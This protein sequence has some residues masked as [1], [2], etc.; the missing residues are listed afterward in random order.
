M[1]DDF[2]QY[3][4]NEEKVTFVRALLFLVKID[5]RVDERERDCMHEIVDIYGIQK[6][7]KLISAPMSEEIILS[8]IKDNINDR[9]KSLFL[10]RELLMMANIDDELEDKEIGLIRKVAAA[11]EVEEEKVSAINDLILEKKLWLQ[12]SLVVMEEV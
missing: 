4:T 10:L 3:L 9:Q 7:I 8:E 12:K 6:D 11:L 1:T 2:I 5:G